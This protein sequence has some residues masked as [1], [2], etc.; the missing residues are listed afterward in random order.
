MPHRVA[1]AHC[2]VLVLPEA[3]GHLTDP[4]PPQEPHGPHRTA[5]A[6]EPLSLWTQP[7]AAAR[8]HAVSATD[9]ASLSPR[10]PHH[11]RPSH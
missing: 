9:E 10:G 5:R 1:S 11:V 7:H 2:P 4:R 8:D 3:S 6:R